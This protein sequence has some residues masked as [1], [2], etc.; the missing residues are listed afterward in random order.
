M[1]QF[2]QK[3]DS[4]IIIPRYIKPVIVGLRQFDIRPTIK[5]IM[6][7]RTIA[8]SAYHIYVWRE[9]ETYCLVDSVAFNP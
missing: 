1:S 7:S 3:S 8:L 4:T 5:L 9:R 2:P 6:P